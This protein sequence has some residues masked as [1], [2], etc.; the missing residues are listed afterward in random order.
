MMKRLIKKAGIILAS[1]F[2]LLMCTVP[3]C[4]QVSAAEG[5]DEELLD[6][7]GVYDDKALF[8]EDELDNL[9]DMVRNLSEELELYIVIYLGNEEY[10]SESSVE[11][12]ADSFY[13]ST[14]GE[15]TDGVIYYMDLSENPSG[16]ID[17]I[18]T[19]GKGRLLYD[20]YV[21][22]MF[23]EI[24][25][26]LPSTGQEIYST[27]IELAIEIILEQFEKYGDR[28]P[29]AFDVE[30]DSKNDNYIYY[31]NGAT[32]ISDAMPFSM[33]FSGM[34]K[35]GIPCGI[36]VGL[37]F[38]FITRWRYKFKSSCNPQV[39]VARDETSFTRRDDI[40]I[41]TYTTRTKIESSSGGRGGRSGGGRSHGGGSRRR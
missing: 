10:Y 4:M 15:Y 29:G 18:S 31:K 41:R 2:T 27:Q 14:F 25:L 39:Y 3:F 8:D 5:F 36:V 24:F 26:Y 35:Y 16:A 1:A 33:R 28:E 20:D 34:M 37:L 11:F 23:D 30:Y 12:F 40:F 9:N 13:D 21:E 32:V 19:S 6:Y 7:C 38:Y 22:D 17:T